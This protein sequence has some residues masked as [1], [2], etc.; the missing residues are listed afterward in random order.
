MTFIPAEAFP[1]GEFVDE[2]LEA[3]GWSRDDFA[4]AAGLPRSVVDGLIDDRAALDAAA[5]AGV[6]RAFGQTAQTW[7]NLQAQYDEFQER[8]LMR[9]VGRIADIV[10]AGQTHADA[11]QIAREAASIASSLWDAGTPEIVSRVS[12]ERWTEL[13]SAELTGRP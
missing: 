9:L 11:R 6:A 8:M 5:A 10:R 12:A 2:E 7:L 4:R 13:L 3:R 1:P